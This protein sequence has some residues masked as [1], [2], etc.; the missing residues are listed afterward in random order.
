[1]NE[2]KCWH[3]WR[4]DLN[5]VCVVDSHHEP[6]GNDE[7]GEPI[8]SEHPSEECFPSEQ[9]ALKK[10]VEFMDAIVESRENELEWLRNRRA[11]LA[12][13]LTETARV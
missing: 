12:A 9:A 11:E 5:F 3:V 13:D 7:R 4:N 1:M 2:K 8:F 6:Y 10:A